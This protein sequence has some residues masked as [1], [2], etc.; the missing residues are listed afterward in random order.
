LLALAFHVGPPPPQTRVAGNR[1][2]F[3]WAA[4][5]WCWRCSDPPVSVAERLELTEKFPK[6]SILRA[7]QQSALFR[8]ADRRGGEKLFSR[9]KK[10][11]LCAQP[12]SLRN[13][14][15]HPT[16]RRLFAGGRA[17]YV[18][19]LRGSITISVVLGGFVAGFL[20]GSPPLSTI[21]SSQRPP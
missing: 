3:G 8:F 5:H 7:R 16:M 12:C 4:N 14:H 11:N 10:K 1:G 21:F 19:F 17:S 6:I 15:K 20:T 18:S 13:R 9:G 2:P